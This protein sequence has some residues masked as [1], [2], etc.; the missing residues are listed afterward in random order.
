VKNPD[1]RQAKIFIDVEGVT[2]AGFAP[3]PAMTAK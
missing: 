1:A 2:P 3:A